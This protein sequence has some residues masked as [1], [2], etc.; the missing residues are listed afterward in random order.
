MLLA[1]PR[2]WRGSQRVAGGLVRVG[3]P[4]R[5][6]GTHPGVFAGQPSRATC[7]TSNSIKVASKCPGLAPQGTIATSRRASSMT[8]SERF[9]LDPCATASGPE[10]VPTGSSRAPSGRKPAVGQKTVPRPW[11][12]SF[13]SGIPGR[14]GG[15]RHRM[16]SGAEHRSVPQHLLRSSSGPVRDTAS[17]PR[18]F[19]SMRQSSSCSFGREP[20]M[21]VSYGRAASSTSAPPCSP[22]LRS[23]TPPRPD[24]A[25]ADRP[26]R[27]SARRC[28]PGKPP[29]DGPRQGNR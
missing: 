8:V 12:V 26:H 5:S 27:H 17:A 15:V 21:G 14:D 25:G 7:G 24:R 11:G 16:W 10:G 4:R 22:V 6:R 23:A 28:L 2:W 19:R 29:V 9:S 3:Q 18:R 13:V 1:I 20:S